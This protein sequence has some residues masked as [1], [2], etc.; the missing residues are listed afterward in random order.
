MK[1]YNTGES[2]HKPPVVML[3]YGQGG[4]GKTTFASTAPK[5]IL[6]DCEN[7]AK[8]FGLR[9]IEMDVAVVEEWNDT[10]AFY[11]MVKESDHETIVI[12]PIGELMEKLKLDMINSKNGKLVMRDG[13]P[14]MAGWGHMKD[15]M[16][17]FIKAT[18]D[19][20]KHLVIIAHVTERGDEDKLIKRP[21]LMTKLSE[22]LINIVDV[23]GYMTTITEGEEVKRIIRIEP[24][25]KYEAKDRTGQLGGI[26]KPDFTQIINACQ[27]NEV[28]GWSSEKAKLEAEKEEE[29]A[30]A[31]AEPKPENKVKEAEELLADAEHKPLV[32]SK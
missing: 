20:G 10:A 1:M 17:S 19:L 27:G 12:D 16:R 22:E 23:V 29:P 13:S 14:T 4:V 28:Y 26:I 32:E 31:P 18:R 7:G 5:P 11:R 25:D 2:Q 15:K 24:S 6:M 8:Y 3:V 9:G 21:L 30:E